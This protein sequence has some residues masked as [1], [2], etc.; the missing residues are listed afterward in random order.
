M[1]EGKR[2][3]S[4]SLETVVAITT[5]VSI[6]LHLILRYFTMASPSAWSIPLYLALV[7][8]GWPILSDL[9]RK[10][11]NRELGTDVLAGFAIITAV[12]LGEY[13]VGAII[14]LMFSGGI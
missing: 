12:V 14:V 10:L 4:L 11:W 1:R 7:I 3:I 2:L 8:G 5:A 13:L 6:L 9:I